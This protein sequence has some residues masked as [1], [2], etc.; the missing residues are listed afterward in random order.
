METKYYSFQVPYF[1]KY[2]MDKEDMVY[3]YSGIL[4]G[5]EKEWNLAICSNMDGTGGYYAKWN[6]PGRERQIPCVFTHMWIL[7]NLIEDPLIGEG[8]GGKKLQRGREANHNRL[9]DTENKLRAFTEGWWGVGERGNCV[10]GI[11]EGT[12]WDEHWVLYVRDESRETTPKTKSTLYTL[13]VSQ[14]N[15]KLYFKKRFQF[16]IPNFGVYSLV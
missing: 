12:C 2:R 5:N 13:Y 7:R 10:M 14:L 4:L 11:E 6:K 16:H 3:I 15:N 1:L 9:L 8:K